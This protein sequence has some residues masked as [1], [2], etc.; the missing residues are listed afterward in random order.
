[1]TFKRPVPQRGEK[2]RAGPA[3]QTIGALAAHARGG[4]RLAD[5]AL[6]DEDG[7]EAELPLGSPTVATRFADFAGAAG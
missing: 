2:L 1:V 3:A 7:E 4:R 5:A 6:V